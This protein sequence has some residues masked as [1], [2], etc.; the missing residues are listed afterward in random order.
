MQ[1]P[2]PTPV[3]PHEKKTIGELAAKLM[4]LQIQEKQ[5]EKEI[6]EIKEECELRYSSDLFAAKTDM[7]IKF[8]DETIKKVRLSRQGSGTYFKPGDDFKDEFTAKK[9]KLEASFLT[10][11]KATMAEKACTWKAQ[12]VKS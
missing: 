1:A 11:G 12:V 3:R 6:K 10:A 4:Y 2:A 9:H 5:I 8:S 7:Q